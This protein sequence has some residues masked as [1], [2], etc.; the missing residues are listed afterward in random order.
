MET[1][2]WDLNKL[3]RP[4][5][6]ALKQNAGIMIDDASPAA[7]VAFYRACSEKPS[8]YR[9]G[10][11][12]ACV[13]MR[14]LWGQ[15]CNRTVPFKKLLREIYQSD[16]SGNVLKGRCIGIFDNSWRPD[17]SLLK[18]LYS[19]MIQIRKNHANVMPDFEA[20]SN[21]LAYWGSKNTKRSYISYIC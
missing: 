2:K 15:E 1:T 7:V 6:C 8:Q 9:A 13:C 3:R 18:E 14:C 19:I 21:D 17:G 12:F 16:K 10:I 20:L 4:E 11:D 5:Y